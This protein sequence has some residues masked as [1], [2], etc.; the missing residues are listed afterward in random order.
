MNALNDTIDAALP[1]L[2][3]RL[4]TFSE[5]FTITAWRDAQSAAALACAYRND[6][7]GLFALDVAGVDEMATASIESMF[8]CAVRQMFDC[9]ARRVRAMRVKRER[10]TKQKAE[11]RKRERNLGI[12]RHFPRRKPQVRVS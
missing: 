10:L 5:P 3:A 12:V 11:R 7:R 1:A 6:M 9:A 8:A 2:H 4:R